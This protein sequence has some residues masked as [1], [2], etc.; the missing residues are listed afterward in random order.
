MPL[1]GDGNFTV[2]AAYDPITGCLA[3]VHAEPSGRLSVQVRP[4][5]PPSTPIPAAL[6]WDSQLMSL[7]SCHELY[8]DKFGAIMPRAARPI[9]AHSGRCVFIGAEGKLAVSGCTMHRA[10]S[11][12]DAHDH[13][14]KSGQGCRPYASE[15]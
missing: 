12:C 5:E 9:A 3:T 15:K 6:G 7:G 4:L 8:S 14:P 11:I 1:L 13:R 10:Y 2:S